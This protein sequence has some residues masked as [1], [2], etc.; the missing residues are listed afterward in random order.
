VNNQSLHVTSTQAKVYHNDVRVQNIP[1]W[2]LMNPGRASV[3]GV[4]EW[5]TPVQPARQ[6]AARGEEHSAELCTLWQ[7][8]IYMHAAA[9]WLC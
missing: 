1:Y 5:S 6:A 4:W 2:T 9:S 7:S 8:C 3:P